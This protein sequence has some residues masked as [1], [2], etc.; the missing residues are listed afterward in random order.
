MQETTETSRT[1]V[2]ADDANITER[3]V[4]VVAVQPAKKMQTSMPTDTMVNMT[5]EGQLTVAIATEVTT[6]LKKT[7]EDTTGVAD[8]EVVRRAV[9]VENKMAETVTDTDVKITVEVTKITVV[10]DSNI[11]E[12]EVDTKATATMVTTRTTTITPIIKA[13]P[14]CTPKLLIKHSRVSNNFRLFNNDLRAVTPTTSKRSMM[15]TR[16]TLK[17]SS[18]RMTQ[19]FLL[20]TSMS[21]GSLKNMNLTKDTPYGKNNALEHKNSPKI[22]LKI[23]ILAQLT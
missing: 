15:L 13:I 10:A 22:S 12:A 5:K 18:S 8:Q 21:L 17:S 23:M 14:L 7:N 2:N 19:I 16:S 4:H 3:V 6:M 9:R 20:S 11:E 1:E